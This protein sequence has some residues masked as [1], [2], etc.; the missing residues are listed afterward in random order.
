MELLAKI[1]LSKTRAGIFKYLFLHKGDEYYLRELER[2]TGIGIKSLQ[3]EIRKLVLLDILLERKDGNRN[4]IRANVEHPL[5]VDFCSIVNKLHGPPEQLRAI[6]KDIHNIEFAFIFGS[7]A[8]DETHAGS[9]ID[10]FILGDIPSKQISD[11]LFTFEKSIPYELNEY[12][13]SLRLF[14]K[15]VKDK[16]HFLMSLKSTTKIFLKGDESEFRKLYCQ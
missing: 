15:E 5:Y 1:L 14:K 7:F 10:L 8:K 9:D 13:Y 3:T 12:N 16:K 11:I 2:L 4:Y 6:F